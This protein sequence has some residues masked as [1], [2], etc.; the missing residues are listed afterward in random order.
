MKIHDNIWLVGS[1]QHGFEM[2]HTLDCNVY[3]VGDGK[4][5]ALIDAGAGI[6][7]NR[8]VKWI[9]ALGI[10]MSQVT[11]LFLTHAH[12]DHA[13]GANYF[14]EAYGLKV[15]ASEEAA[16]WIASADHEKTSIGQAIASGVYPRD[17]MYTPCPIDDVV[18]EGDMLQVG[19]LRVSIV[20]TPGHAN[21]H[22]SFLME[23]NGRTCIFVGD[24]MF[25]G[26]KI[27]IQNSWDCHIQKYAATIDK[28]A[29]LSIDAM[30]P[31]HGPFLLSSASKHISKAQAQ[32][33][34]LDI[35]PN[36]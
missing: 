15:V 30:F 20:E 24:A 9:E 33:G 19:Q 36:L 12:G 7:S 10:S 22:I 29:S 13:A 18:R 5:F 26:G 3:L 6:E 2:T 16:P 34:R 32:F 8:I 25:A 17:Y 4:S 14:R 11:Q 35:P 27:F 23:I 28:L 31:G 21:G 1:G